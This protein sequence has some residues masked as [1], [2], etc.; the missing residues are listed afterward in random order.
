VGIEVI[1]YTRVFKEGRS[2]LFDVCDTYSG[3]WPYLYSLIFDS[4]TG[5]FLEEVTELGSFDF[6]ALIR[7]VELLAPAIKAEETILFHIAYLNGCAT[8][9]C[10]WRHLT[11][12][13]ASKLS[14]LGFCK[15]AGSELLLLNTSLPG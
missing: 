10:M 8:L 2:T 3:G 4:E 14:S 9:S 15:I 7:R 6:I 13:S 11:R 1:D 12:V 5:D